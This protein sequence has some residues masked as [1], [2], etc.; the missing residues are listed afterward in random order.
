[1]Q[2]HLLKRRARLIGHDEVLD[3]AYD[4]LDRVAWNE[5]E[6]L[7][8]E[9]AEKRNEIISLLWHSKKMRVN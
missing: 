8:Y 3:K 7:T 2:K 1:M 5:E 9:Q 6:L 4:E